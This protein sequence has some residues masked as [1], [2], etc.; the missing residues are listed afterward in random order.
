[1]TSQ[2]LCVCVCLCVCM[3][4]LVLSFLLQQLLES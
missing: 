3:H 4:V 2:A 1:M